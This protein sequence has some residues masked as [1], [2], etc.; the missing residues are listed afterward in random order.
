M[1]TVYFDH[2]ATTAV[3]PRVFAE[4]AALVAALD[5]LPVLLV[6]AVAELL[7]VALV[8][9]EVVV[10]VFAAVVVLVEAGLDAAYFHELCLRASHL[11]EAD[12]NTLL[13]L[14]TTLH[15]RIH[16]DD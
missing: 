7:A 5:V 9:A 11:G 15:D 8:A 4:M 10:A 6:A 3:D 1:K 14:L 13:R 12:R 16:A 2:A